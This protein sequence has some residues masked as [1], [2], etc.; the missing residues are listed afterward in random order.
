M[1]VAQ[2]TSEIATAET[3]TLPIPFR[4][5]SLIEDEAGINYVSINE[6]NERIT[7][8]VIVETAG[9]SLRKLPL[10]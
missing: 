10:F 4:I 5:K 8:I 2:H 7:A 3:A 6:T 9:L 1:K